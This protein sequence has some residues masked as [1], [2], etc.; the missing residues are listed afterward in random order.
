MSRDPNAPERLL[1]S[2]NEDAELRALLEAGREELP[3]AA[4]LDA[5]ARKLGPILAPGGTGHGGPGGGQV[6]GAT[7]KQVGGAAV[8]KTFAAVA[9]ATVLGVT[10]THFLT[11]PS[12]KTAPPPATVSATT[13]APTTASAPPLLERPE[14]SAAPAV[15]APPPAPKLVARPSPVPSVAASASDPDAEVGLLQRAQD[16]LSSDPAR[17]LA[18]A[19]EHARRFPKGM[20][21]EEREVLA[22][23][24][25]MKLGRSDEANARASRFRATYPSSTHLPRIESVVEAQKP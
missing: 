24:A 5:L 7:A 14:P 21:A 18:L 8:A 10:A 6:A 15:S 2:T 23:E 13:A 11:T 17:S 19:S 1:S 3:T 4:E 9:L 12:T 25:L 16:A 22:I 20:L